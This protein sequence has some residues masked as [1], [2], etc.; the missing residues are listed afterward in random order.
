MTQD[1]QGFAIRDARPDEYA[2]LGALT[3][4]RFAALEGFPSP[5]QQPEYYATLRDPA[6]RLIHPLVRNLVA[7]RGDMIL[8]GVTF[9]GDMAHYGAP[10]GTAHLEQNAAGMRLLAVSPKASGQGIGRA[11]TLECIR[12]ARE[13]GRETFILHST[14]AMPA[15]WKLYESLGFH[16][17]TEL[18]FMQAHIQVE[19]FRLP[20][21]AAT[22]AQ[23]S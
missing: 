17:D 16:R 10:G 11:L 9:I 14:R 22:L 4:E 23:A 20:L 13:M 15:A 6:L 1:F 2:V 21:A 3:A 5:E 7:V 19:G 12:L 18:D 8:G